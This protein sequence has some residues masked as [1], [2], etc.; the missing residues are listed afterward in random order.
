MVAELDGSPSHLTQCC[1]S[2]GVRVNS[3]M[4]IRSG[5]VPFDVKSR[6]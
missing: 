6:R 5:M 4:C 3:I 2:E 1:R